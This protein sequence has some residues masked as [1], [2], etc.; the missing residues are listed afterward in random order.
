MNITALASGSSGNAYLVTDGDS[1]IL[2]ECGLPFKKLQRALDFKLSELDAVLCSH[3]HMDHARAVAEVA[4]A[5]VDVY[6]SQGTLDALGLSGHR[7]HAVA[8]T[9]QYRVGDWTILPFDARH[10][11]NQPL[12]FLIANGPHKLMY[13]TDSAYCPYRFE[14]ITHWLI[15]VNYDETTMR[16][17]VKNGTLDIN[18]K[19]RIIRNHFSLENAVELFKANDLSKVSEIVLIHLSDANSDEARFKREI[20]EATAKIVKIA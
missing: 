18:L 15:E 10:D 16:E 13:L 8:S 2:I 12:G 20:Q 1:S 17:N 4:R 7:L 19:N 11:A 9:G 14:G 5:G 6:V 3:E